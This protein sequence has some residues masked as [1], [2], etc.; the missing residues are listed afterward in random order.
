VLR[1]NAAILPVE[2]EEEAEARVATSCAPL[3][4]P[5][6]SDQVLHQ[7]APYVRHGF[8]FIGI[9]SL[10]FPIASSF[11]ILFLLRASMHYRFV[12]SVLV[13]M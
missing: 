10:L 3:W 9:S 5:P 6:P 7:G 4:A 2:E 11:H 12:Y 1:D 13:V 8:L